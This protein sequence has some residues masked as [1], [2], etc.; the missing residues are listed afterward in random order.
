MYHA[1]HSVRVECLNLIGHISHTASH[2]DNILV[3][4]I[5]FCS[6]SDSRVRQAAASALVGVVIGVATVLNCF[7]CS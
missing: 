2:H 4:V 7:V 1:N 5:G 3:L 6:D